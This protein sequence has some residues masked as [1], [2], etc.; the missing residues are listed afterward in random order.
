M[1]HKAPVK[2]KRDDQD[3]ARPS[4]WL[5][6]AAILYV[7]LAL[8]VDTLAVQQIRWPFDWSVFQ[9]SPESCWRL[10]GMTPPGWATSSP[11][12]RI[13]MFKLIFWFIVPFA[14]C[15]PRMAWRWLSPQDWKRSDWLLLV[16]FIG[17]GSI[18]VISVGFIPALRNAYPGM[19]HLSSDI[20]RGYSI[21]YLLWV[22][23]WLPGWEFLHR[24]LLL[25]VVMRRFPRYGWLLI[26]AFETLYHL[27]KPL[28]EAGG[29][30]V[31][32][33]LLTG[34]SVKRR[35]ALLPFIAHLYVEIALLVA[36]VFFL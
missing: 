22:V 29:M 28:L 32:S 16:G 21:G 4:N 1:T 36:L 8:T 25:R 17:L 33:L 24:Y 2:K 31:F 27:Q 26:P 30:L 3:I 9:W 18:A 10:F 19:S 15:L 34:W 14:I 20:R 5:V 13:D 11:V 6:A 35:N 12:S 7:A 23:S